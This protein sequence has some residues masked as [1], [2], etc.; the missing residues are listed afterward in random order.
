MTSGTSSV[1]RATTHRPD[2]G[3]VA[4][5]EVRT[6]LLQH[7]AA[8]PHQLAE[9]ILQ[10]VPGERVRLSQRPIAHALSPELMAGVDCRL[11]AASG[12]HIDGT[13]TV[14]TRASITGGTVVQASARAVVGPARADHRLPWSHYMARPGMIETRGKIEVD[15]L[16]A[17]FIGQ[18]TSS[19]ALDLSALSRRMMD[20]IQG[21]SQLDHAPRMRTKR[22]RLRW[23]AR[24]VTAEQPHG[25][26]EFAI[27]DDVLRTLQ[28]RTKI[29]RIAMVASL[30]ENLALHDWLLSTLL[31][32][33][34]REQRGAPHAPQAVLRLRPAIDS[35]LHLWMPAAHIDESLHPVWEALERRAG[36]TR[37]WE[38]LRD[39]I[40][41]QV[42]LSAVTLMSVVTEGSASE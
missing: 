6:G 18:P 32:L 4:L 34:E 24:T 27:E 13:G 38:Q 40:R 35:L 25:L 9:R 29:D 30:C 23:T 41:D 33:I 31:E 12:T 42:T 14:L 15:D 20:V 7:S 22:T 16:A 19:S 21:S 37:Q 1:H 2:P 3:L 28:L 11:A 8:I 17:G 10:L 5:G 26:V 36:F 39:R